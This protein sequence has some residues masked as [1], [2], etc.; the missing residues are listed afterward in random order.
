MFDQQEHRTTPLHVVSRAA[1]TSPARQ[2][3][4]PETVKAGLTPKRPRRQVENDE[5]GA[6][7]PR[8]LRAY[9]RRVGDGDVEALVLIANLADDINAALGE[10]VK[11][12][13]AC[14]YSWAEIGARLGITRQAAQQRWG[15][16][17]RLR[18]DRADRVPDELGTGIERTSKSCFEGD[19]DRA[20]IYGEMDGPGVGLVSGEHGQGIKQRPPGQQG[21][22]GY[23]A[24]AKGREG[25]AVVFSEVRHGS[26]VH[27]LPSAALDIHWVDGAGPGPET[28]SF[29]GRGIGVLK[30][31]GVGGKRTWRTT[32]QAR[33]SIQELLN[34][35]PRV[36]NAS[37]S[38]GQPP[39][40]SVDF[41]LR[42]PEFL[43]VHPVYKAKRR[44]LP[45]AVRE[46]SIG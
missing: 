10:A 38:H 4:G 45:A 29:Q 40:R 35:A 31:N 25:P 16:L 26:A 28:Y 18:A 44:E 2:L 6:F 30:E 7:V 34:C 11:G 27:E 1:S 46:G 19:G 43:Y 32:H 8:V 12:L 14:G 9:A 22:Q 42:S 5:Y 23:R 24:A 15:A 21:V 17:I 41:L 39:Y 36:S 33:V 3:P 13:R 37:Q 20:D